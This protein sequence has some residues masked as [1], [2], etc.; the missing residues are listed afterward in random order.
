MRY[1][2]LVLGVVVLSAAAHAQVETQVLEGRAYEKVDPVAI[3]E[4]LDA[5]DGGVGSLFDSVNVAA[6]ERSVLVESLDVLQGHM[7]HVQDS[8]ATA[9]QWARGVGRP[10]G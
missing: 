9:L 3:T 1:V 7:A 2:A 8:L 10:G 4:R 5:L 6:G